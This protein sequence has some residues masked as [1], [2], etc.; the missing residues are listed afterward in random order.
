[1]I[2][3]SLNYGR[4]HIKRFLE[5]AG[6]FQ[7]VLDL[8]A[9]HGDDL[10][11]AKDLRPQSKL[12]AVEVYPPYVEELEAQG[13]TVHTLN[14]ELDKL[15][16][17]DESVDV[18]I[19][20]QILEHV[21]E[22]FWIFHE[23]SR[24]LSVG[25]SFIIGVPNL[26]AWHN[27]LLVLLGFQPTPLKNYSAHVRGWSKRDIQK[28]FKEC[29]AGYQFKEFG[30]SNFYPFPPF[31]ARPLAAVLPN[32][33]WGVFMRWEKQKGYDKQFLEYPVNLQLETNFYLGRKF[34]K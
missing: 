4:H 21:K 24:V 3:R 9:G 23:V 33:A 13:I 26:V 8:G 6:N 20:N 5:R 18:I 17:P 11:L 29:F 32:M 10:L 22:V 15:P 19:M 16:F 7:T 2:D 34:E 12:H 27:R 14:I 1:L 30:G 31:L 25:G 28:F